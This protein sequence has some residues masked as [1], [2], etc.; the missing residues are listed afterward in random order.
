M[1]ETTRIRELE[2]NRNARGGGDGRDRV[3]LEG[4]MPSGLYSFRAPR[5]SV[6]EVLVAAAAYPKMEQNHL[7]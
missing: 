4:R 3:A 7:D 2:V 1:R 6:K 5:H